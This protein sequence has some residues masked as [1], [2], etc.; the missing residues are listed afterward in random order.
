MTPLK[1][2]LTRRSEELYRDR[3]KFR[4]IVVTL[5]PAGFIG[6]RLEKCR[7]QENAFDARGLRNRRPHARHARAGRAPERQAVPCQAR[8]PLTATRNRKRNVPPSFTKIRAASG[9]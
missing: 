7:R 9:I 4:R 6:L 5:Y 2:A 8:P 3:S 1:K